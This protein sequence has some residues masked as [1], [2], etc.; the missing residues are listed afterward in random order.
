M[1][2]VYHVSIA[3]GSVVVIDAGA[4]FFFSSE[5]KTNGQQCGASVFR[6]DYTGESRRVDVCTTP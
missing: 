3:R 5:A 1:Y 6:Y 2:V 4:A